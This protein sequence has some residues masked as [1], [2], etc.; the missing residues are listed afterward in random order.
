MWR[1]CIWKLFLMWDEWKL[2]RVCTICDAEEVKWQ[3]CL[4]PA[5]ETTVTVYVPDAKLWEIDAPCLYTKSNLK[6]QR[7]NETYDEI[8]RTCRCAAHGFF[9]NRTRLYHQWGRNS[10]ARVEPPSGLCSIKE[11]SYKE[12]H[13]KDARLIKGWEP[14][15]IRLALFGY[16]PSRDFYDACDEMGFVVWAEFRFISIDEPVRN[17]HQNCI[18]QLKSWSF[19]Y[20]HQINLFLGYFQWIRSE[21]FR[22]TVNWKITRT[23]CSWNGSNPSD[24]DVL[25]QQCP[26]R[27][28]EGPMHGITDVWATTHYFGWYG[29]KNG[30]GNGPWM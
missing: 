28:P 8:S 15:L 24:D 21:N 27:N 5:D 22:R 19:K 17:A 11:I 2:Y 20:N 18:I 10:A 4:P 25:L 23:E 3:D 7:R 1:R 9:C 29:G 6:L 13:C 14:N 30:E 16:Q 12:D 26:W